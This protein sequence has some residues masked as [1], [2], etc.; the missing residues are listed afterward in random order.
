MQI[1][2][3]PPSQPWIT[4]DDEGA[5]LQFGGEVA[6]D[7]NLYTANYGNFDHQ[8]LLEITWY[9]IAAYNATSTLKAPGVTL[10]ASEALN[11]AAPADLDVSQ[12]TVSEDMTSA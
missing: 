6:G 11:P 2:P 8:L 12:F 7:L 3:F 1:L 10:I 9:P 5:T 4:G